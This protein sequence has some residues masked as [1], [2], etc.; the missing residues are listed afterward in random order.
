MYYPVK[1][2]WW[3]RAMFP[4]CIWEMTDDRP[5]VHLTFDDGPD[6]EMTPFVLD[7]LADHGV[8]ATFFCIGRNVD[9]HPGIYERI[10]RE[11]HSVGNHTQNHLNGWNTDDA[12]YLGDIL[13][14]SKKIDSDL[15]RPP[16]GRIRWS[17]LRKLRKSGLNLRPVMW[18]LLSGDFDTRIGPGEC[19]RNVLRNIRPG[20][21]ITFHDSQKAAPRLRVALPEILQEMKR[22]EWKGEALK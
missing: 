13:K 17:Q 21:I 4:G 3:M 16:Y 15:F 1:T 6:P 18:T 10:L 22:M 20:S 11:G 14:A 19:I 9:D 12:T 8:K 7:L 5:V 2:R